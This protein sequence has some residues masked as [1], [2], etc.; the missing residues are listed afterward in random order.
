M[1]LGRV[2]S[3]LSHIHELPA[4]KQQ[5]PATLFKLIKIVS[6]RLTYSHSLCLPEAT[7]Q[8]LTTQILGQAAKADVCGL[9][10]H[11]KLRRGQN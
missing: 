5:A 6:G 8:I 9:I 4:P 7:S 10:H 2:G 1:R 11:T 3:R